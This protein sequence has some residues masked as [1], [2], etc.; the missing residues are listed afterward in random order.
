MWGWIG[1]TI[2][3]AWSLPEPAS[4]AS[5]CPV[6]EGVKLYEDALAFNELQEGSWLLHLFFFYVKNM[7]FSALGIV[8]WCF[9]SFFI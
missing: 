6:E 4:S 3:G 7:F 9:G 5:Q 1:A 8:S 2:T